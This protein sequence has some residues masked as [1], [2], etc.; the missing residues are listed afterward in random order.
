MQSVNEDAGK[1]GLASHHA[2]LYVC[3]VCGTELLAHHVCADAYTHERKLCVCWLLT[4]MRPDATRA[5]ERSRRKRSMRLDVGQ[6]KV[7]PPHPKGSNPP[8]TE[9][10]AKVREAQRQ[11]EIRKAST[12]AERQEVKTATKQDLDASSAPGS[13]DGG[14]QHMPVV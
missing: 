2:C 1:A 13:V 14:G 7:R 9:R 11:A 10:C 6:K 12:A 8:R 5:R 3:G 4:A